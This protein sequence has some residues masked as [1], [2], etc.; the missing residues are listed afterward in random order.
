MGRCEVHVAT[1][2]ESAVAELAFGTTNVP[3]FRKPI[4]LKAGLEVEGR[5]G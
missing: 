5:P 2:G 3:P 4:P 1:G